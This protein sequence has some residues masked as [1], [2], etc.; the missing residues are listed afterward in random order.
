MVSLYEGHL[1]QSIALPVLDILILLFL[2][3]QESLDMLSWE[4][5]L[6]NS[7]TLPPPSN[8]V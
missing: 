1:K 8:S 4:L 5:F 2:L 3:H 6:A 7:K